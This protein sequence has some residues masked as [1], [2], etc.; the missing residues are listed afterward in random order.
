M[1]LPSKPATRSHST[2]RVCASSPACTWLCTASRRTRRPS[3]SFNYMT[4]SP[5]LDTARCC[6]E[7][8]LDHLRS[9]DVVGSTAKRRPDPCEEVVEMRGN[10]ASQLRSSSFR[11]VGDKSEEEHGEGQ[12]LCVK[13]DDEELDRARRV[14][15]A[16]GVC[17]GEGQRGKKRICVQKAACRCL[18]MTVSTSP[19]H[20]IDIKRFNT[21]GVT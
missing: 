15:L 19:F 7:P 20:D 5:V 11:T 12:I 9:A 18:D 3:T 14:V 10:D 16:K 17:V 2:P 8:T 4:I 21:K 6:A 13:V 1:N